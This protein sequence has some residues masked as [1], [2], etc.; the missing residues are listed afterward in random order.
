MLTT[1]L[2]KFVLLLLKVKVQI[3][4]NLCGCSP[5]LGPLLLRK[6]QFIGQSEAFRVPMQAIARLGSLAD[7]AIRCH[8]ASQLLV[9]VGLTRMA[10]TPRHSAVAPSVDEA[11]EAGFLPALDE[12]QADMFTLVAVAPVPTRSRVRTTSA[13]CPVSNR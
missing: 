1:Q 8:C 11:M 12:D 2:I 5:G 9:G 6:H 3:R 4:G 10:A 7:C 13:S